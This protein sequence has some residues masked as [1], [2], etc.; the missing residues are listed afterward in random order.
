MY[1]IDS[2]CAIQEAKD[3]NLDVVFPKPNELQ[4][5]IDSDAA[6]E[7][8]CGVLDHMLHHFPF[9]TESITP[10]RSGYPKR[11][12][13]L[14]LRK[15]VTDVQRIALQAI[16]GSDPVRELLSL[17]RIENGDPHPTLFLEKKKA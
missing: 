8:Y 14:T 5:D 13:V 3:N 12:I 16:L 9:V 17:K 10:S 11:H 2:E 6:Y 1:S 4:V 7:R 15:P